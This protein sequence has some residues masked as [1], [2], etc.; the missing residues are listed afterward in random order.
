MTTPIRRQ[1][2]YHETMFYDALLDVVLYGIDK[3]IDKEMNK[4]KAVEFVNR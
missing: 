4:K 1:R 2:W 3:E